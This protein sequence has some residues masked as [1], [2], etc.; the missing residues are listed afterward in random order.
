MYYVNRKPILGVELT[1]Q[2]NRVVSRS[3]RNVIE[4]EENIASSHVEDKEFWLQD[5]E[6]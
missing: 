2:R 3:D 5:Y 1:G 4:S 6:T